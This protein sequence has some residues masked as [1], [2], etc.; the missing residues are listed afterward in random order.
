MHVQD[1][2]CAL[3]LQ[4]E[5]ILSSQADVFVLVKHIFVY[6]V[7]V[8]LF[9]FAFVTEQVQVHAGSHDSWLGGKIFLRQPSPAH[10]VP[11]SLNLLFQI[12]KLEV[13]LLKYRHLPLTRS[14]ISVLDNSKKKSNGSFVFLA[15]QNSSMY[16]L[17]THWRSVTH[18]P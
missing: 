14:M 4:L 11:P 7:F 5:N 16:S 12:F 15:L 2:S 17:I 10:G 1:G 18:G 9:V 6:C 3:W 8:S 13:I